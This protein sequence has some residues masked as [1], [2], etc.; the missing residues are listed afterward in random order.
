MKL[1]NKLE[2]VI[3]A[4]IFVSSIG[5]LAGYAYEFTSSAVRHM[6]MLVV[7]HLKEDSVYKTYLCDTLLGGPTERTVDAKPRYS[8][9]FGRRIVEWL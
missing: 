2:I 8:G 6:A 3:F 1:L 9:R 7:W 5:F 4:A